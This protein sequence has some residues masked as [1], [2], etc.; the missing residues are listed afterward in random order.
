[1]PAEVVRHLKT[2]GGRAADDAVRSDLVHGSDDDV[3][4]V[5]RCQAWMS[6]CRDLDEA[7]GSGRSWWEEVP[8]VRCMRREGGGRS[9][10]VGWCMGHVHVGMV[11]EDGQDDSDREEDKRKG[12]GDTVEGRGGVLGVDDMHSCDDRW[13]VS[14]EEGLGYCRVMMTSMVRNDLCMLRRFVIGGVLTVLWCY[15]AR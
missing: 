8:R 14:E 6:I 7:D 13:G 5:R 1:M 15:R 12:R 3:W 2:D 10:W 11:V 9:G 4:E